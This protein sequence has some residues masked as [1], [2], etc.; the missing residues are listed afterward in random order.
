MKDFD[1]FMTCPGIENDVNVGLPIWFMHWNPEANIAV[2]TTSGATLAW[3]KEERMIKNLPDCLK[4]YPEDGN[5][6]VAIYY[7]K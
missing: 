3:M 7:F 2:Q 1:T 4:D 6:V 5:P